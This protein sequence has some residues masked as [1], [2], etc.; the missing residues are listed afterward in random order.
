MTAG[1]EGLAAW[2]PAAVATVVAALGAAAV[3]VV[4]GLVGGVWALLRWRRDVARE[5]RDRAW[6]R[7]VWTV[8]QVCHGDVGRGEI[9]FASANTM[10]EMQ[11]LRDED[12]VYG[13]VVLRM[14]TGRD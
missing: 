14:I 13:K 9:G 3:T 10:Y 12:A 4:A 6:S 2:P 7:F 8:E 5:E 1:V 11:I